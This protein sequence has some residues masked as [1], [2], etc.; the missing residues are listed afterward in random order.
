MLKF[1]EF[2]DQLDEGLKDNLDLIRAAGYRR[3]QL[4]MTYTK[5]T[6]GTTVRRLIRPYEIARKPFGIVVYATDHLHGREQIHSFLARNINDL[7][8]TE[9]PFKPVWDVKFPPTKLFR[10]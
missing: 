2:C 1:S 6:D 5:K 8:A 4:D 10:K 7:Q 9:R 3:L